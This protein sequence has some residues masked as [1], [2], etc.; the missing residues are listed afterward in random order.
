MKNKQARKAEVKKLYTYNVLCCFRFQ[1]TFTESEVEGIEGEIEPTE[2]AHR[3]LYKEVA[4]YLSYEYGAVTDLEVVADD[5]DLLGVADDFS[6][7]PE[8]KTKHK[9]GKL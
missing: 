8:S 2:K 3:E 7:P 4:E 1:H 6:S 5:D 9:K